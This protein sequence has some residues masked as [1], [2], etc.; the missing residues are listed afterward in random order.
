VD[1]IP[2]AIGPF[3]TLF[4]S[5]TVI[6]TIRPELA[7]MALIYIGPYLLG[8][9]YFTTWARVRRMDWRVW[10]VGVLRDNTLETWTFTNLV[11]PLFTIYWVIGDKMTIGEYMAAGWIITLFLSP[12]QALAGFFQDVRQN[13]VYAERLLDTLEIEEA[14]KLAGIHDCIMTLPGLITPG[15]HA[16]DGLRVP[17]S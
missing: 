5:I 2:N 7:W 14:A 8:Q 6:A 10:W 17:P 16:S 11:V 12:I 4:A 9:H 1:T 15:H 3:Q 13:L